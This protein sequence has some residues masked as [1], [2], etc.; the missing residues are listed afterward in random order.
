MDIKKLSTRIIVQGVCTLVPFLIL[1]V[2]R[3][4]STYLT[5]TIN[6]LF[7]AALM[8]EIF[9]YGKQIREKFMENPSREELR[10]LDRVPARGKYYL[11]LGAMPMLTFIMGLAGTAIFQ[12]RSDPF[13]GWFYPFLIALNIG[14]GLYNLYRQVQEQ[15]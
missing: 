13:F 1:Q 11:E 15:K 14:E 7:F 12:L 10:H 9:R 3:K 6:I 2:I 5:W 8:G 4:I